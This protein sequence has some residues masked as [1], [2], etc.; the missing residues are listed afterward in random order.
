MKLFNKA[1]G[2]TLIELAV[3]MVVTGTLA[4]VAA[5]KLTSVADGARGSTLKGLAA[6]M[7]TTNESMHSKSMQDRTEALSSSSIQVGFDDLATTFG[8]LAA[9][10]R[11]MSALVDLGD[12]VFTSSGSGDT[13]TSTYSGMA[14]GGIYSVTA[15]TASGATATIYITYANQEKRDASGECYVSY[16]AATNADFAPYIEVAVDGC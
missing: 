3:V 13:A 12:T 6:S 5:P 9:S 11:N 4:A 1:K 16:T 14:S 7:E 8:W 2:F 10:E 15:G